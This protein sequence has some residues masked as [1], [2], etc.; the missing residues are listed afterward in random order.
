MNRIPNALEG[1]DDIKYNVLGTSGIPEQFRIGTSTNAV[2]IRDLEHEAKKT[3]RPVSEIE[4][5]YKKPYVDPSIAVSN[6]TNQL[7]NQAYVFLFRFIFRRF[8][9]WRTPL[10]PPLH[11]PLLPCQ[12][13]T[14]LCL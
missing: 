14:T 11:S 5:E 13:I 7:V 6:Y 1:R 12:I 4:K 8:R 2:L 3:G 10:P 9:T